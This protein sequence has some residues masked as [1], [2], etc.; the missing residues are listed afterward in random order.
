MVRRKV[1]VVKALTPRRSGFHQS[2]HTNKNVD[3]LY[4]FTEIG[5]YLIIILEIQQI[6][7]VIGVDN[8][9][10]DQHQINLESAEKIGLINCHEK[11]RGKITVLK[12]DFAQD[13]YEK[14][15]YG[16]PRACSRLEVGQVF[17][18]NIRWDPPEG[19]CTW[20]WGDIRAVIMS[21]HG[22]H[23]SPMICCCTDGLRP[24]T[25]KVER[26]ELEKE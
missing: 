4:F 14:Y 9:L 21:I 12:K 1:Q 22:G 5:L 11:Y 13:L 25:F 17:Y 23:P 15:P 6:T 24:V 16:C 3:P 8:S 2:F 20:A 7:G 19:F 10:I 18:T 26:V